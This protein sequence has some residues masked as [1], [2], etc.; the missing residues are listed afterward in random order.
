MQTRSLAVL[1]GGLLT[2]VTGS[3][4][5]FAQSNWTAG[6]IGSVTISCSA[7]YDVSSGSYFLISGANCQSRLTGSAGNKST[8]FSQSIL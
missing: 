4:I 7:S 8:Y 5:L 3:Q 2:L 6:D 1:A